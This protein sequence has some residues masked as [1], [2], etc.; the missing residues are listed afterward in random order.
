LR[1]DLTP[2][3]EYL[4]DAL[5]A[6]REPTLQ[7]KAEGRRQMA[8]GK[9]GRGEEGKKGKRTIFGGFKAHVSEKKVW[10]KRRLSSMGLPKG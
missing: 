1:A 7:R 4:T 3:S 6:V 10:A 8:E 5:G 2:E 9:R